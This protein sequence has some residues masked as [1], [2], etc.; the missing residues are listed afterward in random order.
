M[1]EREGMREMMVQVY[2]NDMTHED[3]FAMT[4]AE[5]VR[6]S[7]LEKIAAVV[8]MDETSAGS[9]LLWMYRDGELEQVPSYRH[10]EFDRHLGWIS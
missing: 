2:F 1:R 9:G 10:A 6:Y 3:G 8:S 7:K 4:H 5:C